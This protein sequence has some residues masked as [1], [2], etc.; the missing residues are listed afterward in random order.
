MHNYK[1]SD[2]NYISFQ[3]NSIIIYYKYPPFEI[4]LNLSDQLIINDKEWDIR[5]LYNCQE[6]FLIQANKEYQNF[7]KKDMPF[8][9]HVKIEFNNKSSCIYFSSGKKSPTSII[10]NHEKCSDINA[11]KFVLGHEIGHVFH[12]KKDYKLSKTLKNFYIFCILILN[13]YMHILKIALSIGIVFLIYETIFRYLGISRIYFS[14]VIGFITMY[15]L[16]SIDDFLIPIYNIS[17]LNEMYSS[18]Q[19]EFLC[20]KYSKDNYDGDISK[21]FKY[22]RFYT[23]CLTHPNS[24]LRLLSAKFGIILNFPFFTNDSIQHKTYEEFKNRFKLNHTF[25]KH[26]F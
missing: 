14:L 12:N 17:K 3:N 9:L 24:I 16:F 11:F 10:I 19:E 13:L 26:L 20:D 7:Y 2:I 5:S 4:S 25:I 15:N 6:S 21:S 1:S 8:H 22:T 23:T 18:H